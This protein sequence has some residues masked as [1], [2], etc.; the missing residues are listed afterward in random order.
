MVLPL[1]PDRFC[2]LMQKFA[3]ARLNFLQ[4]SQVEVKEDQ[5]MK[6]NTKVRAG[7]LAAN[8]NIQVR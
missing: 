6:V 7:R 1:L 2:P 5:N 8:H 4:I 3:A